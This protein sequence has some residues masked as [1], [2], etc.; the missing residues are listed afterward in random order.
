M[1]AGSIWAESQESETPTPSVLSETLAIELFGSAQAALGKVIGSE[2]RQWQITGV[3]ADTRYYGLDRAPQHGLFLPMSRFP[4]AMPRAHMAVR[5]QGDAPAG[6]AQTLRTAV[7]Q[8]APDLPIPTVRTM[9][10]WLDRATAGRRF[11]SVLFGAFGIVALL[12]AAAGLYGTLLYNV[13]QRRKELGIRLALGAARSSV[14]RAVVGGGVRLALLGF[15]L[16]LGGTWVAGRFLESRLYEVPTSDPT[17][18]VSASLVLLATAALASWL[19]ARRAGRTDP[20][21]TLKAE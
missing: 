10:E 20:I 7:W 12:L 16:G 19:P 1:L 2:S 11:D 9:D 18:L 8:A 13:R 14:E 4:Y 6:F 3:A 15:I 17:T 5:V 21:E